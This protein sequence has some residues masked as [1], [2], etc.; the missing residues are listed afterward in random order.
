MYSADLAC[1]VPDFAPLRWRKLRRRLVP[2]ASLSMRR[3]SRQGPLQLL[4]GILSHL[5]PIFSWSHIHRS[6]T[7]LI[8]IRC[9]QIY[10]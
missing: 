4:P 10:I 6:E 9:R 1:V 2:R 3:N 7:D 5:F 8:I